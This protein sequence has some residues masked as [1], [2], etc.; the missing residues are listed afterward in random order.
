VAIAGQSPAELRSAPP[1]FT[2]LTIKFHPI[3]V[4]SRATH[5]HADP[6]GYAHDLSALSAD[7]LVWSSGRPTPPA[8]PTWQGSVFDEEMIGDWIKAKSAEFY[9]MRN[10]P[11]PYEVQ[12][13]FAL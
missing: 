4:R 10:R 9:Q 2:H 13:Y 5:V 11:H 12:L 6:L 7:L 3:R 8:T 1:Y